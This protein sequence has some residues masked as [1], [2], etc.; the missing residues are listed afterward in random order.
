MVKY[1]KRCKKILVKGLEINAGNNT[2]RNS[3]K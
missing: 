1:R 3:R 2:G